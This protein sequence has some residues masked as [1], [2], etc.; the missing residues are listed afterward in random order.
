MAKSHVIMPIALTK[1]LLEELDT[2]EK[3]IS[4]V[5]RVS[6]QGNQKNFETAGGLLKYCF[7]KKHVSIFDMANVVLE[8]ET[9]RSIS[10]Q[11]IRHSSLRPQEFSQRYAAAM[12]EC[13]LSECRV[14]DEKNRQ[15]S[16]PTD[17]QELIDW[18]QQ[19]QLR[20]HRVT[21]EIYE[22]ACKRG[23]AKEQARNVLCEG[24][25]P[26]RMYM[27]GTIRSWITFCF[28]RCG[29]ETQKEH[30]DIAKS[31]CEYLMK[32]IPVLA[33]LLEPCMADDYSA[34]S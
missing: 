24:L 4:Y 31:I 18:W 25:T 34:E 10:R 5:A 28:V 6:N 9:T 15:N 19:A 14:Q 30:R 3:L 8:V 29:V 12:P 2:T 7:K 16:F 1:G 17:D 21:T 13:V 26:T 20:A 33:P 23:I 32:E 27:N 11:M 22:E